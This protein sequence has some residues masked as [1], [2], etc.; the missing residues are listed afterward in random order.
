MPAR[1]TTPRPTRM[2]VTLD[3]LDGFDAWLASRH[4]QLL[5]DLD[6]VAGHAAEETV[7]NLQAV[8]LM[9]RR[10]A[11]ARERCWTAPTERDADDAPADLDAPGAS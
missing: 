6:S 7:T 11:E 1:L 3:E 2:Q 8:R 10:V 9:Q 4:E 5:T